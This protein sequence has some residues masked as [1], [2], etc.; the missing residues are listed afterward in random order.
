MEV[1][2][3]TAR[4]SYKIEAYETIPRSQSKHRISK[5]FA[6]AGRK[7]SAQTAL[8]F[9]RCVPVCPGFDGVLGWATRQNTL[10]LHVFK[11]E[12]DERTRDMKT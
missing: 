7:T 5:L 1:F 10:G 6:I 4:S 8:A 3:E 11:Q 12:D 2:Y 9:G